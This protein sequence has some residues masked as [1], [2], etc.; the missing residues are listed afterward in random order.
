MFQP[1]QVAPHQTLF[2]AKEFQCDRLTRTVSPGLHTPSLLKKGF[3]FCSLVFPMQIALTWTDDVTRDGG[4][5]EQSSAKLNYNFVSLLL[6][7][8]KIL[9]K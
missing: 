6:N 1:F 2:P 7:L 8:F 9:K 3:S 4:S 5:L